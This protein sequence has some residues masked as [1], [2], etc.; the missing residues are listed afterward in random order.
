MIKFFP[1]KA[2]KNI[3]G[4]L[5]AI[6]FFKRKWFFFFCWICL[7]IQIMCLWNDERWITFKK[8]SC[9]IKSNLLTRTDFFTTKEKNTLPKGSF[10]SSEKGTELKFTKAK[11]VP[12]WAILWKIRMYFSLFFLSFS[13]PFFRLSICMKT[14]VFIF[15]T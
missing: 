10:P 6:L 7:L 1:E 2:L 9:S 15:I 13:F 11:Q 12:I 14:D 5:F 8:F 4:Y 3:T